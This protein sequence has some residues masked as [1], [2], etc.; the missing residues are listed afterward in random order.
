VTPNQAI[1][2]INQ[3]PELLKAWRQLSN[4][5]KRMVLKECETADEDEIAVI[6]EEIIDGQ[7]RLF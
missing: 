5:Q 2:I 6:I 3:S 7:R 1:Y 4:V